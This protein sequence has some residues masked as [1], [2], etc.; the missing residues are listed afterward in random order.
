M[1]LED[2]LKALKAAFTSKSAEAEAF[3]KEMSEL[4][5]KNDTL[6]AEYAAAV[7]KLEA[8]A[9]VISERDAAIAKVE[10]LTKALAS[11]E[12][13]KKQAVT[14][15][16][17]VGKKAASI[18]ASVGVAP[19]EVNPADAV[20]AKSPEEVWTEYCGMKDPA[21]KLAFYNK[22]RASIVAHLGIK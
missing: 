21:A 10:E 1:T 14:Q 6:A 19:V 17:S 12:D 5:T 4:K 18:A 3:A 8:S 20:S 22:N 11:A 13:L 9:A 15:I 16:E 7:E 2:S